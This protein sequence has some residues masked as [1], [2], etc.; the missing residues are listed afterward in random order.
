MDDLPLK[1][2]KDRPR[3]VLTLLWTVLFVFWLNTSTVHAQSFRVRAQDKDQ[4]MTHDMTSTT[5]VFPAV[6]WDMQ[7]GFFDN[8][9]VVQWEADVFRHESGKG[10]VADCELY[11][12]ITRSNGRA[13]WTA[14]VKHDV[15][16]VAKGKKSAVVTAASS[17][18][19][20][21]RAD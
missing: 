4:L 6:R 12:T 17:R 18:D 2:I 5:Q 1:S 7:N 13:D 11:L 14:T 19:G 10:Y 21:G 9:C 8:G 16:V 15:S 20:N 3:R